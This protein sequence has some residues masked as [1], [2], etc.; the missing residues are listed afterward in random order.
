MRHRHAPR[1]DRARAGDPIAELRRHAG[2]GD[3]AFQ[4]AAERDPR[5]E[6]PDA[7]SSTAA[8]WSVP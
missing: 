3:V 6:P 4:G 5:A 7:S 2:R 1:A 8:R